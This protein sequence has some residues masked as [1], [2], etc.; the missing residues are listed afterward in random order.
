MIILL[1]SIFIAII[2]QII[3]YISRKKLLEILEKERM[4]NLRAMMVECYEEG[5]DDKLLD[6][7]ESIEK[8]ERE[9]RLKNKKRI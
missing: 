4:Y 3:N 5:N 6:I 9:E 2:I 8:I 7:Y 1:I